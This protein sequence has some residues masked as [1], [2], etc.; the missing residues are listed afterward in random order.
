MKCVKMFFTFSL[1]SAVIST[2]TALSEQA[3][4]D[5]LRFR[6][7]SI[8]NGNSLSAD[9]DLAATEFSTDQ[10]VSQII[11]RLETSGEDAP[12]EEAKRRLWKA[13]AMLPND[14]ADNTIAN[15][16]RVA[17]MTQALIEGPWEIQLF[18]INHYGRIA[19]EHRD[20]PAAVLN[21]LIVTSPRLDIVAS[22]IQD[23]GLTRRL[24][25]ARLAVARQLMSLDYSGNPGL[26]TTMQTPGLSDWEGAGD[27]EMLQ[28]SALLAVLSTYDDPSAAAMYVNSLPDEWPNVARVMAQITTMRYLLDDASQ[29]GSE[30]WVDEYLR[31]LCL[32]STQTFRSDGAYL[33]LV[34]MLE[35]YPNLKPTI[36]QWLAEPDA[37][38]PP[39]ATDRANNMLIF[40]T[41]V[42]E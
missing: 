35:V 37:S 17:A 20:A 15:P 12:S 10:V 2:Q 25:P 28:T 36:C 11:S 6:V 14:R 26:E 7:L 21:D 13:L 33:H 42:C 1:L 4:D 5:R 23:L 41:A 3:A 39:R 9:V 19:P 18:I 34:S 8:E 30:A 24:S 32:P 27:P 31:R 40:I 29:D 16:A 38:C 22:A